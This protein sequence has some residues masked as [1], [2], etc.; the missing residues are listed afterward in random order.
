VLQAETDSNDAA[1]EPII[2][3]ALKTFEAL[4]EWMQDG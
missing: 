2:R 4:E 1:H 3:G